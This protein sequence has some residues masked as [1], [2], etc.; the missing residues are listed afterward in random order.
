MGIVCV[1]DQQSDL[2]KSFSVC[3]NYNPHH[4][5]S[6][7]QFRWFSS[8]C[9]YIV[10]DDFF[11]LITTFTAPLSLSLNFKC[12]CRFCFCFFISWRVWNVW[13]IF[14]LVWF[15]KSH[16][17]KFC[18]KSERCYSTKVISLAFARSGNFFGCDVAQAKK[19]ETQVKKNTQPNTTISIL[20][21]S[22]IAAS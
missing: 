4:I 7:L 15:L 6:R 9:V 18:C 1:S 21:Y 2:T 13:V 19:K 22:K 3:L 12:A 20:Y 16:A 14:F 8:F 11:L 10:L 5:P 17:W